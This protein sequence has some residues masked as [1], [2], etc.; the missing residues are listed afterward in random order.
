MAASQVSNAPNVHYVDPGYL[1]GQN[2]NS[3]ST[4]Q[5]T[6]LV[7]LNALRAALTAASATA[8]SA[9]NLDLMTYNDMIYA[10]RLI[11]GMKIN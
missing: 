2:T 3:I 11:K 7:H 6:D 4:A 9:A 5:F 1:L 8:Y 10:Y